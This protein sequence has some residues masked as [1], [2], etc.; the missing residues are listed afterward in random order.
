MKALLLLVV[1]FS[2]YF[3][4]AQSPIFQWVKQTGNSAY[5]FGRS[6]DVDASGN[7]YTL[8]WFVGT[9]DADPG[10]GVLNFTTSG[11]GYNT[12]ISKLDASGNLIW[13]KMIEGYNNS[14][15]DLVL[16]G[17][18]NLYITGSFQGSNDFNPSASSFSLTSY[19]TTDLDIFI[20]KLDVAGNFIWAKKMGGAADDNGQ[21]ID[22][23][24]SGN[25]CFTGLFQGTADFDPSATVVNLT[26]TGLNDIYAIKLDALGNLI[27]VKQL[28]GI[29]FDV[30]T[31]IT[32]DL[33]DNVLVTGPLGSTIDFDPGAPVFNL[34]AGGIGTDIFVLK[35]NSSGAFVWAKQF[36]GTAS[37]YNDGS[38]VI[39]DASGNVYTT[40]RFDGTVDFDPNA[41][42]N[43]LSSVGNADIFISKLDASGNYVWVKQIGGASIDF[44]ESVFLDASGNVYTTGGFQ[45]TVDFDPNAATF[46]LSSAGDFDVFISKLDALGNFLWAKKLG[47]P[48]I[49]VGQEV[50]IDA[51]SNIYTIG[52]FFQTS[53]FDPDAPVFNLTSLGSADV[54]V[55]KMSQ[56]STAPSSP[57]NTTPPA[58]Q[59]LC[60]GNATTLTATSTGTV[61]W[62]SVSTSGTALSTG[63]LFVTPTL[64]VG[65][66]TY[67]AEAFDCSV[68]L[69]RTPVTVTVSSSPT[70]TVNSATICS[71]QGTA[72]L[73]A[74]GA[75]NYTWSPSLG[76]SATNGSVVTGSPAS[77]QQY[78]VL[79]TNAI[80]CSSI[81][82]ATITVKPLPILVINNSTICLGQETATLIAT[83]ALNY[84]W[85]PNSSLSSS[86]GSMVTGSPL[87]TEQYTVTGLDASGCINTKTASIVV[88]SSSSITVV[89]VSVCSGKQATLTASGT[90]S[91]TWNP[92]IGLSSATGSLVT[93]T[94]LSTQ[95]FTIYGSAGGGCSSFTTATLTVL[96]SPTITV[97]SSTICIGQQ[98]ASLTALG[99]ANYSWSPGLSSSTGSFVTGTPSASQTY[100]VIGSDV[101][102]CSNTATATITVNSLP[103]ITATSSSI[104]I[105]QGTGTL[106]AS[107]ALTYTWV[108]ATGLSI[109]SGSVVT[110]SPTSTQSYT[111]LGIDG[112]GCINGTTTSILVNSLPILSVNA[113]TI[114]VAQGNAT[115]IALGA[116]NYTWS[117]SVS[118]SSTTGSVVVATT[119]VSQNYT[120]Q[121]SDALGCANTITTSVIVVPSPT[122]TVNSSTICVGQQTASLTVS[123]ASTYSWTPSI[124]L[125]SSTGVFVTGTP[126]T[127]QVYTL[128]GFVGTG[129]SN[130]V[131]TSITVNALPLITATS[132]SICLGQGIGTLTASGAL[133]YTWFPAIGLSTTSGS[134]VTGFP[135]STQ[136]YTVIGIDGLGCINGAMATLDVK[137]LP[138]LSISNTT[139]CLSQ[140]TATLIVVGA[141]NY[142]WSPATGLSATTGSL[143]MANPL[144]NQ[145]YTIQGADINTCLNTT[146]VRVSV[147]S[148]PTL[149]VN[150]STI[151]LGQQVADLQ[152]TGSNNGTYSWQPNVGLS[153]TT[154]SL[155]SSTTT[156][157]TIYT[158]TNTTVY[159]CVSTAT[160]MV[161]VNP[162]PLITAIGNTL[163]LLGQT[164]T[165]SAQGGLSYDWRPIDGSISC[166]TCSQTI[167]RPTVTTLYIVKGYD[168]LLCWGEDTV[169][170]KVDFVC[171]DF[172]IPN[173]FSPNGD[174]LND[175]V[176]VHGYCV[177]SYVLDIYS[178]WGEKV[179]S[180]SS[181][182]ESWDGNFK[183]KAM[184]TG[185]F[186][187]KVNVMTIDNKEFNLKGNITLLR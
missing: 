26:A 78:T 128:Q 164:T 64:S 58:S 3:M 12:V 82:N 121:G 187:Y 103:V 57:S 104:C 34:A 22:V 176:N 39:T 182:G 92:S 127:S 29:G 124:G 79:G 40:G 24:A 168:G 74:L 35:L 88:V 68:S 136:T 89:N 118:L 77:T 173:V 17:L 43:N 138:S 55:H 156:L 23:D 160:A 174:G 116:S 146:T 100:T 10:P 62:Y 185:V 130:T 145:T 163:I 172:F 166:S 165:V 54:F 20:L 117:P 133:T 81:A 67:Y 178:R 49:D 141:T 31:D 123:G 38:S 90:S 108:P 66:Y 155:V 183:G 150:S 126:S 143:V 98:T 47:G 4:H 32:I 148:S 151:C 119:T 13:A 6:I 50:K 53:D 99:A 171:G 42:V 19:A 109:T 132:S 110:G 162:L 21:Y 107:G 1:C 72:T 139:I 147:V 149:S 63:T 76:L 9:I 95:Q 101:A 158:V 154:G 105:G 131:T 161:V 59:V 179:F 30:V 152:V 87:V 7:V 41:G 140:Q 169:L 85:N 184:D 115:L 144:V 120:V 60:G 44:G 80:G 73:S 93:I 56:C 91:Y 33:S 135:S 97:S 27:W 14:G 125:S 170:V 113:E 70:I 175:E 45:G 159:G 134:V 51:S 96:A 75:V 2:A 106:T 61:S 8:S 181:K 15:S 153:S 157:T 5:D 11:S 48:G 129:C 186:V 46:N 142:T 112:L 36:A 114:C 180:T 94:P 84:T 18:G 16:D 102:G 83:G 65:T 69:T 28:D 111:V 137:S 52:I 122:L 86:T 71:G 25:V 177:G 37:S 167:V